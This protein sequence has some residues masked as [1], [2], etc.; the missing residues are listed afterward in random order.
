MS[1]VTSKVH[2]LTVTCVSQS[3]IRC[4]YSNAPL[5]FFWIIYGEIELTDLIWPCLTLTLTWCTP[6][7]ICTGWQMEIF[8]GEIVS[9]QSLYSIWDNLSCINIFLS[10]TC[11]F[12]P[13]LKLSL[14]NFKFN[15][16]SSPPHRYKTRS[17]KSELEKWTSGIVHLI[18]II[19][20]IF[21]ILIISYYAIRFVNYA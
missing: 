16:F 21:I 2:W 15:L 12:W 5:V 9:V 3:F 11:D 8:Q 17:E 14:S 6:I 20:M 1:H 18:L 13:G 10:Q 4:S 7:S 19:F